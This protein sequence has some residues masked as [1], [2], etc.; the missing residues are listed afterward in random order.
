MFN[1]RIVLT[2]ADLDNCMMFAT[3]VEVWLHGELEEP[4]G[5]VEQYSE[6]VIKINGTY[7]MRHI[8]EIRV[9]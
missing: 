3:P 2:D 9:K 5:F 8:C 7:Y 4:F 1:Q 6:D